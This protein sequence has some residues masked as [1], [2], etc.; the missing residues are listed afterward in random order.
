MAVGLL[1][2]GCLLAG[3][4]AWAQTAPSGAPCVKS[5]RWNDDAPYSFKTPDGQLRGFGIE[6]MREVL[7]RMGCTARFVEM[8]WARALVELEAGRLDLLPG[9]LRKPEREQFAYFSRPM[10]RSPN[11]LF[12]HRKAASTYTVN[13][14]ADLMGTPFRLGAQIGVAYGPEFNALS[15]QTDFQARITPLAQ[16]RHGWKMMEIGRLDGQI[17]DEATALLELKQ[18]GLAN[19]IVRTQVVVSSEPALVAFS[20]AAMDMEFVEAFDKRLGQMLSDG[21]YRAIRERYLP[22]SASLEV[23]ACK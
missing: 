5:V 11:V 14:L 20:K 3:Q 23:P 17:A 2:W 10:N 4:P 19:D 15:S 12:M 7:K 13:K 9:A 21:S 1:A 8:P 18:M 6:L 16:R 22:C